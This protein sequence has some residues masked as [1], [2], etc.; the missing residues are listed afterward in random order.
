M[1]LI[2]ILIT[3][4]YVLLVTSF[5]IGLLK[6][7]EFQRNN[8]TPKNSFSILIPFRDEAENL[9]A[10]LRSISL[11]NY[12][13]ELFEVLLIND[14]SNDNFIAIIE[15]FVAENNQLSLHLIDNIRI[16]NSPKKDAIKTGVEH[17]KF[18]WI[19]TTDADCIV[20]NLWLSAYD[21]FIQRN[22]VIFISGPVTFKTKQ[23]FLDNFQLLDFSA[24][25]GSTIG[26]FGIQKPFLCN[27]ANLCYSK[28]V[29]NTVD[30]YAGNNSIASGDDIFLLEKIVAKYPRQVGYLK[31]FDALVQT[32]PM[33]NLK[34][35]FSQRIRWASK[36]GAYQ[37]RF[38]KFVGII[39]LL[40]NILFCGIM[41]S[42]IL[43]SF[44]ST[45]AIA[46]FLLKI[47]VDFILIALTLKFKRK[48]AQ[49][50][51]YP[52]VSIIHPFFN[53]IV[54]FMALF[55]KKYMWKDRTFLK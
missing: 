42:I 18:D 6:T 36:A 32:T 40:M 23:T 44:S 39:I 25:I 11:L 9:P 16:S 4:V 35:L 24:L 54:G 20:P 31:S 43:N 51:Y 55:K 41:I 8:L 21:E 45:L 52:I 17:S 2:I 14:S 46:I 28:D 22:N 19:L 26:A 10:L 15:T 50:V 34:E 37:N 7:T 3:V 49:L 33:K 47:S 12:P 30:G 27:G 53:I 48:F 13:N 29:F 5:I 1:N 38:T